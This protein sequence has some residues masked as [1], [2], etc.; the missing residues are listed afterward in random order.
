MR[1]SASLGTAQT[2]TY[3]SSVLLDSDVVGGE[4]PEDVFFAANL[5]EIQAVGINVLNLSQ[6]ADRNAAATKPPHFFKFKAA[7]EPKLLRD[8]LGA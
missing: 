4:T 6:V 1:A 8:D 2:L 7:R 5:A 3:K